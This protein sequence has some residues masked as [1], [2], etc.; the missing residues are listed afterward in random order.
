MANKLTR[1]E[2]VKSVVAV[3]GD[4]ID[5]SSAVYI[6]DASKVLCKCNKCGHTWMASPNNLKHGKGCPECNHRSRKYTLDEWF[7]MAKNVHKGKYDLSLVNDYLSRTQKMKIICHERDDNG[8]EHG[9]FEIASNSFLNGRG[10]PKCALGKI[11]EKQVKP[12]NQM[13]QDAK[14]VHGDKYEYD[15]STYKNVRTKMRII[16]PIHGEFW[17]TPHAHINKRCGCP[18]CNESKLETEMKTL[19]ER[20]KIN[21]KEKADNKIFPWIGLQHLDF[22]LPEKKL[23]IECQGKQHYVPIDRFGGDYEFEKIKKRDVRKKKLCEENGITLI[24]YTKYN[25]I[26]EDASTFKTTKKLLEKIK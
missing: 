11:I 4:D 9:V 21:F 16:C 25:G 10:C 20:E 22:Y 6:N 8:N 17:Q 19:L 18:S 24:Y 12:F 26:K 5:L 13:V 23:A 2:F 3:H 7:E 14:G 15:K 1:E